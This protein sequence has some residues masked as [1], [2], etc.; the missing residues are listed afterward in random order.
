MLTFP[1][2]HF[3]AANGRDFNAMDT[4]VPSCLF[5]LDATILSSYGGNGQTWSNLTATGTLYDFHLGTDSG[6]STDDPAFTGTADDEAAFFAMDG[7]DFFTVKSNTGTIFDDMHKT[8]GASPTW[9]CGVFKI[10]DDDL[11]R[12]LWGTIANSGNNHGI[13]NYITGLNGKMQ[14]VQADGS[15]PGH[16]IDIDPSYVGGDEVI[17]IVTFDSTGVATEKFFYRTTTGSNWPATYTPGITTTDATFPFQFGAQGNAVNIIQN[18]TRIYALSGGN[19]IITDSE[20]AN[21][22]TEYVS[23]HPSARDYTI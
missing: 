1:I 18:G 3:S 15:A 4:I 7:G 11:Q 14:F 19:S 21:L 10:V 2:N 8:T 9:L 17:F 23:R 6:S 13:Q 22:F 12:G 20:V 16:T 5:D